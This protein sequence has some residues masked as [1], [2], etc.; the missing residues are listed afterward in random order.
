VYQHGGRGTLDFVRLNHLVVILEQN[1]RQ[2]AP[3]GVGAVDPRRTAADQDDRHFGSVVMLPAGQIRQY[4]GAGTTG[5]IRK[6]QEHR[7]GFS[8]QVVEAV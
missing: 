7:L 4:L 6:D 1:M 2:S 5:G 8:P 3:G